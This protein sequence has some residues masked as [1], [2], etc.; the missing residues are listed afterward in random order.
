MTSPPDDDDRALAAISTAL[1]GEL[2]LS[3]ANPRDTVKI[4][5]G[6]LMLLHRDAPPEGQEMIKG[7]L[8]TMLLAISKPGA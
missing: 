7:T 4:L 2:V 8:E 3:Q 5:I 6:A 1:L